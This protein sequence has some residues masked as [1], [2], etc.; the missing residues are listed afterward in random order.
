LQTAGGFAQ[1]E[2]VDLSSSPDSDPL[3]VVQARRTTLHSG[4]A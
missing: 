4:R 2:F 3:Y 1:S